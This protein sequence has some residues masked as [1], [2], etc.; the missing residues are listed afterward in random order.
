MVSHSGRKGVITKF[1]DKGA[2]IAHVL[3]DDGEDFSIRVSHLA[4][5]DQFVGGEGRD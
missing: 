1:Q 4:H 2:D 3:W 5:D